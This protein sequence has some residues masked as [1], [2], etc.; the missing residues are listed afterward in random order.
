MI[1]FKLCITHSL[2]YLSENFLDLMRKTLDILGIV[3]PAL[4]IFIS[5]FRPSL[6]TIT[7]KAGRARLVNSLV[8]F[9]AIVLLLAGIIKYLFFPGGGSRHSEP[10]PEPLAVSKHS[11]AFNR[12]V[13]SLLNA[14][15]NMSEAFVNWD[16][17]KINSHGNELKTALNE[18]KIEELKVDTTG[19]YESAL[20]PLANAKSATDAILNDPSLDNKRV[21]FNNL[22]DNIRMLFIV[23]KYDGN[24][25]YWQECP[26]AFGEDRPGNWLSKTD[27]VRNPYLGL[28]H[29]QYR[30]E[31]LKCGGPIDTINFMQPDTVGK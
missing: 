1:Y 2:D 25:V 20:D 11:A 7:Q 3:L 29:P 18:L 27:E 9:S 15:Y 4:I 22:S 14:Y 19:I 13:Q 8:M 17:V 24:K 28:H 12:S 23:V 5:L 26:M 10:D 31:M 30:D 21:A 6:K 16:T